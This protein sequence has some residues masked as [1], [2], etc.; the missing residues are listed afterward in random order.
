MSTP[1]TPKPSSSSEAASVSVAETLETRT[2]DLPTSVSAHKPENL[3]QREWISLA[4]RFP[5]DGEPVL[6][7]SEDRPY[8]Y[9]AAY[10]LKTF[11]HEDLWAVSDR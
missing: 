5:N 11:D 1:D 6:L 2:I 10:L 4:E 3:A 8:C 7:Y 9:Q